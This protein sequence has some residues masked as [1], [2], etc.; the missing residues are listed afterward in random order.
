MSSAAQPITILI[1][2]RRAAATHKDGLRSHLLWENHGK[3]PRRRMAGS[4]GMNSA[5][6]PHAVFEIFNAIYAPR[7]VIFGKCGASPPPMQWLRIKRPRKK[8]FA[9][10]NQWSRQLLYLAINFDVSQDRFNV[11][12]GIFWSIGAERNLNLIWSIFHV[13]F[14]AQRIHG[15]SNNRSTLIIPAGS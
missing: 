3:R 15:L 1:I 4:R 7:L 2:F 6:T 11:D 9:L 10:Y 12:A 8:T 14:T 5:C 13:K